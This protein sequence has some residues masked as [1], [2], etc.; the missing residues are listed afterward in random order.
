[1]SSSVKRQVIQRLHDMK[2]ND[3]D[4]RSAITECGYN[5]KTC[6]DWIVNQNRKQN[7][8]QRLF[9]GMKVWIFSSNDNDWYRGNIASIR[10]ELISIIFNGHDFR[11]L[12][13]ESHLYK[14]QDNKPIIISSIPKYNYNGNNN[15]IIN[16]L[17]DTDEII[18]DQYT[19]P[20]QNET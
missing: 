14:I 9:V 11:W 16:G 5:T 8:N 2:F 12:E 15:S 17:G 10:K 7:K 4:I 13:K 19:Q 20:K 6:A 1:M 18:D 3:T